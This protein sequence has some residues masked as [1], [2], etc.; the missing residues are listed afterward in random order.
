MSLQHKTVKDI[1]SLPASV[2][3][4]PSQS[5][6]PLGPSLTSDSRP[7]LHHLANPDEAGEGRVAA[8][9]ACAVR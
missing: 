6:D 3:S 2:Q 4:S 7:Y 8:V 1:I 5:S 9:K